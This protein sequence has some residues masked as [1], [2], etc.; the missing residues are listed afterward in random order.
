VVVNREE[1]VLVW[2]NLGAGT[3]EAPEPMGAWIALR[4]HQ[5]GANRDAIGAWLEIRAGDRMIRRELTVGGGHVSG[6][7]GWIHVGIGA[8]EQAEVTITWPDG[9]REGPIAVEANTWARVERGSGRAEP[10]TP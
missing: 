6:S 5:P 10:W 1:N 7:L 9:T 2:R 8:E 4:L 3:P